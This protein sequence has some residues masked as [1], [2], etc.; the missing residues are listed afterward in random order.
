L[1]TVASLKREISHFTNLTEKLSQ[2]IESGN[3]KLNM[4][5]AQQQILLIQFDACTGE[6][7]N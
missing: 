3:L 7:N 4:N 6:L 1:P 5:L 2:S